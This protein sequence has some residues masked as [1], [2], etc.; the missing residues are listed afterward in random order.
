MPDP[1]N[2]IEVSNRYGNPSMARSGQQTATAEANT[3]SDEVVAGI[4][5]TKV[6]VHTDAV[7]GDHLGVICLSPTGEKLEVIFGDSV[8]ENFQVKE[9]DNIP[10]SFKDGTLV[11]E[12]NRKVKS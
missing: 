6:F 3:M 7:Y 10:Y 8:I 12:M 11:L 5:T 1:N 9:H 4:N 2:A